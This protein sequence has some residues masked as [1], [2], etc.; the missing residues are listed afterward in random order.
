M[1][2]GRTHQ[3]GGRQSHRGLGASVLFEDPNLAIPLTWLSPAVLSIALYGPALSTFP[4]SPAPY[5]GSSVYKSG[6]LRAEG[7]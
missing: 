1:T 3:R 5:P 4:R 2:Q 7:L 6:H